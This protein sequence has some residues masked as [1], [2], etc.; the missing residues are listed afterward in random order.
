[1]ALAIGSSPAR[2]RP[3]RRTSRPRP[4]ARRGT[5]RAPQPRITRAALLDS[6]RRALESAA[7]ATDAAVA[8]EAISVRE[9]TDMKR[10]LRTEWQLLERFER[11]SHTLLP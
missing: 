5:P 4:R 6:W 9:H 2:S 8:D 11:E 1:M 7:S 10:R 3:A